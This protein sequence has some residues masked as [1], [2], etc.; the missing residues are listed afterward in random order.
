MKVEE[1]RARVQ[2]LNEELEKVISPMVFTL[3]ERVIE[4]NEE[5]ENLQNL[6]CHNYVEG[7]CEFCGKYIGDDT[8][9]HN[10]D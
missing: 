10:E 1:I 6:C 2:T 5:I 3:N 8:N 9:E 7:F 4:I